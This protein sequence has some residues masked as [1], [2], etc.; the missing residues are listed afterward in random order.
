MTKSDTRRCKIKKKL[1]F[2]I[3]LTITV[4]AASSFA[5]PRF[6]A[7]VEQKCNLCHVSP[8]GGGMRETFGSQY[9][10]MTELAVHK[11]P[12]DEIEEF[13]PQISDILS[14]GS[15]LRTQYFYDESA[16]ISSFFQMEGNLYL[17]AQLNDRFS[18]TLDKGLYSGFEAFG[19]AYILPMQGYF[20]MGKF[21][22]TFGWRFADHTS[23]VREK[24]LWPPNSTDTGLE[25][26]LYP[27][28]ISANLGFFNGTQ[29]IF[30]DGKG[31]A[32]SSRLEIRENIEGVGFGL[33]GSV[34]MNDRPAGDVNM[35]GTFYYL[36]LSSGRIIY[37]GEIDWLEDDRPSTA[38]TSFATTHKLSCM[39]TQGVWIEGSYD[40]YD[41]D[42]DIKS[43]DISRYGIGIDYFPYGFLEISPTLRFY[44]DSIADDDYII[45]ISQFHFFF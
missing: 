30:D 37:L 19:T 1:V 6:G 43:G 35:Y 40:F 7:K 39:I 22:P 27:H 21:Q 12:L 42:I 34:F 33:G 41:P 24:M 38:A 18:M 13:Q 20:R 14:L 11:I 25:F 17:D 44:S 26:G 9:F 4:V 2:S 23:F 8:T 31:K 28:G 16:E 29:G 5:L 32:V 36:N 45:F 15:D 10:A 3:I